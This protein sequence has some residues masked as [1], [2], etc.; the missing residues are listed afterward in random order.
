LYRHGLDPI[1]L[2]GLI[3]NR[4]SNTHFLDVN[5]VTRD[6]APNPNENR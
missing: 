6:P 2:G 1:S 4:S 3:A 5:S